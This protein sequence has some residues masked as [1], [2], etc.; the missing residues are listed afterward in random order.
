MSTI[1]MVSSDTVTYPDA[2]PGYETDIVIEVEFNSKKYVLTYQPQEPVYLSGDW[3]QRQ[4]DGVTTG[5]YALDGNATSD[6]SNALVADLI[7][8]GAAND[9]DAAYALIDAV[10]HDRVSLHSDPV[11]ETLQLNI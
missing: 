8:A 7:A 3:V 9:E 10:T 2:E 5:P 11:D 4:D 6:D 1:N